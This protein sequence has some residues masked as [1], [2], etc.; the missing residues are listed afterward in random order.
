MDG[1]ALWTTVHGVSK[2]QTRLSNFTFTFIDCSYICTY[3]FFNR[4]IVNDSIMFLSD[5]LH[6]DVK[7]A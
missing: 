6:N 3:I 2:S 4:N 1:G 7:F 5:I